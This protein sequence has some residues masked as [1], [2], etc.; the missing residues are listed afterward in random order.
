MP[1]KQEGVCA[2]GGG[3]GLEITQGDPHENWVDCLQGPP[4][5]GGKSMLP[6][7]WLQPHRG[8]LPGA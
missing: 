5:D 6:L 7:S 2:S 8:E 3:V 1:R 4:K